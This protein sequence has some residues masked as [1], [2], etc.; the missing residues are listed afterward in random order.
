M[1][2]LLF[3]ALAL[4]PG[5]RAASPQTVTVQN[6]PSLLSAIAQARTGRGP[7]RI[8]LESG[9]YRLSAPVILDDKLSGTLHHPFVLTAK[10]GEKVVISGAIEVPALEWQPYENGIWKAKLTGMRFQRLWLGRQLL[11]RARYPNYNPEQ[12][13]FGGTAA[14]AIAPERIARWK[15]PAG[16]VLL[17]IHASRWGG[18]YQEILGKGSNGALMFGP[19]TG[20]NRASP[21]DAKLRYVENIF[22]ELDAP[23]EWFHDQ[24]NGFLYF[25]PLDGK[26]PPPM[27]FYAS[28]AEELIRIEGYGKPV[29]DIVV[30]G[31]SFEATEVT[32]LKATEPLLRSDWKFYRVGA[33]TVENAERVRIVGSDWHDLGGNGI[34][35]SGHARHVAITGNHFWSIGGSAIA[36][37]G[38]PETVRSPLFE[39]G[40]RLPFDAIDRTPGPKSDAYPAESSAQDN[41]IHDIGLIDKNAAGVEISMSARISVDHNTI[42]RGPRAAINVGDG[43]WGGHVISNNDAFDMV[44]ETGDHGTFNSWGRD[45][46]WHPDREEMDKRVAQEPSLATLDAREPI[47]LRHNRFRCDHGWDIDLDDGATNYRIE[48][49]L[50]LSGGLKLREG[51]YRVVRNNVLVNNTFHPHVWFRDSGDVFEHNVV[52]TAYQPVRIVSWGG[53]VDFNL[54]ANAVDLKQAKAQ[55]TDNHSIAGNPMFSAPA[56]GDFSLRTGSP[57]LKIGFRNFA[58]NDFGVRSNRLRALAD[59]PKIPALYIGE[60]DKLEQPRAFAGMM[61]KSIQTL[62][63]QS[64]AGLPAREGVLVVSVAANGLAQYAGLRP[65]DVITAAFI[66]DAAK[67]IPVP[68]VASFVVMAQGQ[69]WRG[70][71]ALEIVRNQSKQKLVLA[72]H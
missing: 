35:V 61:I 45:R 52:M 16:G 6:V 46:Y 31:L 53:R 42:Y 51:F 65:G 1:V 8:E 43:D 54:F 28:A 24:K 5:V 49:N 14:D 18:V 48:D 70:T 2:L 19:L 72:L 64:A 50:L 17:G 40:E 58:M 56:V 60:T 9:T 55:G 66:D 10:R 4:C 34:V 41:L 39:Y 47:I 33:L 15:N 36:F 57:G 12:R 22:E 68:T 30:Q 7:T 27:G 69:S 67:P 13:I 3:A 63:E 26:R 21:P 59:H 37:V 44:L 38:R 29:H 71:V 62:G 32:I 11:I 25:K 23:G 20:N